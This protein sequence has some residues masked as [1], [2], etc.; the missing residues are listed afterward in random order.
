M[1]W[2]LAGVAVVILG[3]AAVVASGALGGLPPGVDG[4]P[5]PA[6][7]PGE[8][9]AADLR[10]ARFAV[11]A[12]GYSMAQVDALLARLAR[13]LDGPPSPPEGTT[14]ADDLSSME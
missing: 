10:Q 7:P 4:L 14:V 12:R 6:L 13:Q 11:V 8:L 3:L 2:V 5:V 9:T 1:E